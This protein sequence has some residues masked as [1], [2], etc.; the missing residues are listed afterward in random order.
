MAGTP[1]ERGRVTSFVSD[2]RYTYV[3]TDFGNAYADSVVPAPKAG[4]VTREVV[5][6]LPDVVIVRDRVTGAN[7][8]V[9]F[10]VWN[11]AGALNASAR[12]LTVTHGGGHGWLKTLFPANASAQL[13]AQGA[14]DL[15]TIR[16]AGSGSTIE[17]LH[18]IYVSPAATRF[19]PSQLTSIETAVQLGVSFLD[20]QG[21]RWSVAFQR[22]AVGLAGVTSGAVLSPPTGLRIVR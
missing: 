17:F 5:T 21:Q 22:N 15:L 1:Q 16:A 10:H 14:T 13:T 2:P 20:R 11:G 7:P 3:A 8:E 12:E 6:I 18:V 19:V 4:K 9:L